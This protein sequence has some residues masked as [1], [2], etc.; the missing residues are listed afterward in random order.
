LWRHDPEQVLRS[1]RSHQ[2][3]KHGA[4]HRRSA[5]RSRSPTRFARRHS[6]SMY[7]T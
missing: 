1:L 3:D 2:D 6:V 5:L 4:H 7:T